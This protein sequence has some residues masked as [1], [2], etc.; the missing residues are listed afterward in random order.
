MSLLL[1]TA[2]IQPFTGTGC[3]QTRDQTLG[4]IDYGDLF[5]HVGTISS[6]S[7][8]CYDTF[9]LTLPRE[10]SYVNPGLDVY[11]KLTPYMPS[12]SAVK[13]LLVPYRQA[14]E[15]VSGQIRELTVELWTI[16]KC[17][18]SPRYIP[19]N[20]LT[21]WS[22][23]ARARALWAEIKALDGQLK[24]LFDNIVREERIGDPREVCET[25]VRQADKLIAVGQVRSIG[26]TAILQCRNIAI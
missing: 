9:G 8:N 19:D 3:M 23:A 1:P 2:L 21:T 17:L 10:Q 26:T 15:D 7:H 11:L 18:S 16:C 6:E 20:Y 5:K 25:F 24:Q 22:S 4:T 12:R 13:A 14:A